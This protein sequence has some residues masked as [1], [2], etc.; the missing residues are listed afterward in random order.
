MIPKKILRFLLISLFIF[1]CGFQNVL[2]QSV[3]FYGVVYIDNIFGQNWEQAGV[4]I[5]LYGS[6]DKNVKGTCI[7]TTS[8]GNYFQLTCPDTSSYTFYTIEKTNPANCSSSS[9]TSIDGTVLNADQIFYSS[10]S[11]P[12]AQQRLDGNAFYNKYTGPDYTFSG[13]VFE[14]A[15]GDESTPMQGV[16][17]NVLRGNTGYW[18]STFGQDVTT[19]ANSVM[20][21]SS[22]LRSGILK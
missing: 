14:G 17:V 18:Y 5:K 7:A 3:D 4:T 19:N 12:L 20:Y 1:F 6:N 2:A 15:M 13:K 16:T 8:S 11:K 9:A 21:R 10:E 22:M